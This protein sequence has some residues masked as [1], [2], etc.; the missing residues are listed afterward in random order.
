MAL[1]KTETQDSEQSQTE[2]A[3]QFFETGPEDVATDTESPS[4]GPT[5]REPRAR[6]RVSKSLDAIALDL[7]WTTE[8]QDEEA[9][10]EKYQQDGYEDIPERHS[11]FM[12][13]E[14]MNHD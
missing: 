3:E 14:A 1:F 2:R 6:G 13:S 4:Q 11:E 5:T 7:G 12:S 10:H 9:L 8:G